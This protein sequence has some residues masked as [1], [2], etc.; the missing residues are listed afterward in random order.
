MTFTEL[1]EKDMGKLF[2]EF[3]TSPQLISFVTNGFPV[4]VASYLQMKLSESEAEEVSL[5]LRSKAG[6]IMLFKL[7]TVKKGD[8]VAFVPAFELG[9][10][11]QELVDSDDID[12]DVD[13]IEAIGLELTK[14]EALIE[15]A[16]NAFKS[17]VYNDGEWIEDAN[18]SGE[19]RGLTFDEE[20]D[21]A[22]CIACVVANILKVLCKYKDAS[23]EIEYEIPG[24]GKFKVS[25]S[26]NGYAVSLTFDKAF[27]GNC[28]SDKL[29]EK[30]ANA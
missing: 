1:T 12:F 17:M 23:S 28:K 22:V 4:A 7:A 13:A 11:G 30:L 15:C 8:S 25:P 14:N 5:D 9:D 18:R 26:K 20:C 16:K 24:L 10:A 27:K 2:M 21:I 29:A 19:N 3:K 6:S